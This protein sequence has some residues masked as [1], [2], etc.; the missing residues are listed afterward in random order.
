MTIRIPGPLDQQRNPQNILDGTLTRQP[1]TIP[2]SR[3]FGARSAQSLL[4]PPPPTS[5]ATSG[6]PSLVDQTILGSK[7]VYNE[8]WFET[9][10]PN[11]L[12]IALL[13]VA[14][15][16]YDWTIDPTNKG[17]KEFNDLD[18]P[19][20]KKTRIAIGPNYNFDKPQSWRER[21]TLLGSF[22]IDVKTPIAVERTNINGFDGFKW[23]AQMYIED[24]V[25]TSVTS[26]GLLSE[27]KIIRGEWTVKG[28]FTNQYRSLLFFNDYLT[29]TLLPRPIILDPIGASSPC[30]TKAGIHNWI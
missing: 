27:K 7:R 15:K 10:Y 8:R 14:N 25:G 17:K 3:H 28:D 19:K 29:P 30:L 22:V 11:T 12:K 6:S 4:Q 9:R 1:S 13:H 20:D 23:T 26:L 16:I 21:E 2:A 24:N 5:P 18:K